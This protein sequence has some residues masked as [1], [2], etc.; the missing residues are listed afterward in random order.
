[1]KAVV[2][3]RKNKVCYDTDK[4][5]QKYGMKYQEGNMKKI[6]KGILVFVC[7]LVFS[8]LFYVQMQ[9]KT[10]EIHAATLQKEK[11]SSEDGFGQKVA[12]NL[13]ADG[14]FYVSGNGIKHKVTSSS[15][16]VVFTG[17]YSALKEA[18]FT[19]TE[20]FD[21]GEKTADYLLIQGMAER[22][23]KMQLAFYLDDETTP[24]A[25]VLLKKQKK[26]NQWSAGKMLCENLNAIQLSGRH[27][28]SFSVLTDEEKGKL[29]FAFSTLS[30]MHS[31]IPMVEFAID[32]SEGAID[33]MNADQE[34][35]SECY[36]TAYMNIPAGYQSEYS[37]VKYESYTRE[38]YPLDYIRGRG[39][40]TWMVEK[41]PYKVKL[42][43]KADLLGMGANKHWVLLANYYDISMLR[44]KITYW[45]GK[46]LGMKYTPKCE[47]VDVMMNGV[48]LGSYYLSEQVR[49][50]SSRV[51]IDD[52]E[53]NEETK[54]ATELPM[55]SGG[56]LLAMSPYSEAQGKSFTTDKN[57]TF[58]IERPSFEDYENETQ[59]QYIKNYMQKTEDA[60]YGEDFKDSEGVSYTKY[61]DIDSAID[62][63]LMQEISMNGD[64]F[65]STSTYL[66]KKRNGKLYWGPLWDFDFVAWG[67]T[68]YTE[69][70]VEGF[71]Q[72]NN[73]WF[74]RLL[75]DP[76]FCEK[77]RK[78]WPAFKEKLLEAAGDGGQID[79]YSERQQTSQKYNYAYWKKFS[80]IY[81][82]WFD[83][84]LGMGNGP[85]ITY[86]NEVARLKTWIQQRVAWIDEN[87]D[88]LEKKRYTITF[89]IDDTNYVTMSTL[90]TEPLT[91]LPEE[92][93]REGY[94][95]EG[96]F[97]TYEGEEGTYNYEISEGMYLLE[98][99]VAVAQWS[100]GTDT[101]R[102]VQEIGFL[103]NEYY[104]L[105]E[106]SINIPY[107]V[108]PTTAKSTGL[109][110]SSSDSE[111]VNTEGNMLNSTRKLGDAVI[112]VTAPN[113]VN[114]S[115]TVHV[116][117]WEDF[118]SLQ[119]I[120]FEE[121]KVSL[122]IG[123]YKKLN[124]CLEPENV[125]MYSSFLF[126]SSDDSVVQVNDVGYITAVGEGKA[127][128][129]ALRQYDEVPIMAVCD[130]EVQGDTT[131]EPEKPMEMT[132]TAGNLQYRITA[133]GK[134]N[135][136]CCQKVVKKVGKS[137]TIPSAVRYQG[138]NYQVT[139]ISKNVFAKCSKLHKVTFG[140]EI[141]KIDEK[142]F[143]GCKNLKKLVFKG[144]KVK[145][146]GKHA[147]R[148]VNK[149]LKIKA[150]KNVKKK[151]TKMI[152][153]S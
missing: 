67:A 113:G 149:K 41:K 86:D 106:D 123:E 109:V 152:K 25:T 120:R 94:T 19:F 145:K 74:S 72:T 142:A 5:C 133:T 58:L 118:S 79:K 88:T 48:Y 8:G 13:L 59:V 107:A 70:Y 22:K 98:D 49:V 53:E 95:F 54:N 9:N 119:S 20:A 87:L 121:K 148:N 101:K 102:E 151:Y 65:C 114:A 135:T 85:V 50:G 10:E 64:A 37:E 137:I 27:R 60:I 14:G 93:Q 73:T 77:L 6:T 66:Y 90:V 111:I 82:Q 116:V 128:I 108:M 97:A 144:A 117:S 24:F 2:V 31:D 16:A 29:S 15:D 141:K 62:Y 33:V 99:T 75:E 57:N 127:T 139:E 23:K 104:M 42:D 115:F 51:D 80:D 132:F 26:E 146:I 18:R 43:K 35:A 1:M 45:L 38:E 103:K 11:M 61:M 140:K 69:N 32:E 136:V 96:W 28:L 46:E 134:T 100:K 55:I 126:A 30:F 89:K 122:K 76:V 21:F 78:R 150:P 52:L 4:I 105:Q 129:V 112:T 39:N 3:V 47:F 40:S 147:F 63:Y 34:H 138:K 17:E 153:S 131:P 91:E 44:N 81:S 125:L 124:L 83:E 71:V 56:Y 12:V 7:V 36:G 68:E 143:D 92:P 84:E 110:W 130:I